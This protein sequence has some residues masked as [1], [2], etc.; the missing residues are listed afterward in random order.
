MKATLETIGNTKILVQAL[1]QQPDIV[2]SS[3]D[4]S[5]FED[6]GLSEKVISAYGEI[7]VALR[8]I[9]TDIGKEFATIPEAIR[10]HQI[11]MEFNVGIAV[12]G[13]VG[14]DQIIVIGLG[15]KGEYSCKV[16]MTWDLK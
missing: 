1:D 7:K 2:G 12:E 10:P 16:K 3:E 13:K 11:E 5:P 9:A 6:S 14:I 4:T 8:E 15:G